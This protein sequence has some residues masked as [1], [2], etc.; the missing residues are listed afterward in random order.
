MFWINRPKYLSI[1]HITPGVRGMRKCSSHRQ[2]NTWAGNWRSSCK[3]MVNKL[4]SWLFF[5]IRNHCGLIVRSLLLKLKAEEHIS[6]IPQ[7][8]LSSVDITNKSYGCSTALV[9][10]IRNTCLCLLRAPYLRINSKTNSLV[11]YSHYEEHN[12]TQQAFTK[13]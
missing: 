11:K 4:K 6:F 10:Q 13:L 3:W 9:L 2:C 5:Q 8:L 1:P 7:R 12:V